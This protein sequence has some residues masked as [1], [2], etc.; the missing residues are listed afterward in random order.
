MNYSAKDIKEG[1]SVKDRCPNILIQK[2]KYLYLYNS[3]VDK[4]PGVNPIQFNNLED[5]VGFVDWQ[6]SQGIRCPILFLQRNYDPQGKE[7]YKMRPSPTDPQGGLPPNIPI[8]EMKNITLSDL[9]GVEDEKI[10]THLYDAGHDDPPYNY[11]DFPG[12]DHQNQYIG[13]TTPLDKLFHEQEKNKCSDNA[14]D[15]NWCGVDYS[16]DV[17]KAGKY[18]KDVVYRYKN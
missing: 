11:G 13:E 16:R 3:K 18:K 12:F 1:F 14:Y 7:T 4:V 8:K 10:T 6:R 15:S 9:S 17:V 2:G 5:Y